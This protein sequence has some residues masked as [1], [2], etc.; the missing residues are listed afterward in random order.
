MY[1]T[2]LHRFTLP[3][4]RT[5]V[6]PNP[7]LKDFLR[8]LNKKAILEYESLLQQYGIEKIPQ[9][10]RPKHSVKTN[11]LRHKNQ[12]T[13]HKFDFAHFYDSVPF[14]LV[15]PFLKKIGAPLVK[16]YYI[17]PET[18]GLIQG[19]PLS[20]TLAGVA[21]IPFWS[22]MQKKLPQAIITQ[23]SDDLAISNTTL[24]QK[25]CQ[26]LIVSTLREL[27]IPCKIN[28]KKTT[29]HT[30]HRRVTGVTINHHNQ[31]TTNRQF[32]RSLRAIC[33]GLTH[34]RKDI[35]EYGYRDMQHFRQ[36]LS[37]HLYI[38]DTQKLRKLLNQYPA[39]NQP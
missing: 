38:D 34:N 18:N 36:V 10:Y 27:S 17:D 33:H 11:A 30:V 29:T 39:I 7:P 5:V 16:G 13:V 20:G 32:Y 3:T 1:S 19:S 24:S 6:E 25:Q 37:Y 21:L 26:R 2:K 23:Y 22:A 12:R 4:G 8:R 9:A 28:T 14:Y 15:K 31:V 35:T